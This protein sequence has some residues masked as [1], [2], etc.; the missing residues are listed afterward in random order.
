MFQE[1][2]EG[3]RE[4]VLYHNPKLFRVIETYSLGYKAFPLPHVDRWPKH[5]SME[6]DRENLLGDAWC[7]ILI[8]LMA[9]TI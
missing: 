8:L 6:A 4:V 5:M 2:A 3:I 9:D 1:A 7:K